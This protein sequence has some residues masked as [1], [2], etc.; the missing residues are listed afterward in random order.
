MLAAIGEQTV[1]AQVVRE[2]N[3]AN[4]FRA[5]TELRAFEIR[6]DI[7]D[8]YGLSTSQYGKFK[9]NIHFQKIKLKSSVY[10]KFGIE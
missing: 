2:N 8:G 1:K 4:T 7:V 9:S 6:K 3:S 10:V 5:N